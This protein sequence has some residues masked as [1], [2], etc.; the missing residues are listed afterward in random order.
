MRRRIRGNGAR[1]AGF[2]NRIEGAGAACESCLP[3]DLGYRKCKRRNAL[4]LRCQR[5]TARRTASGRIPIPGELMHGTVPSGIPRSERTHRSPA[6][7]AD[8][9]A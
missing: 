9:E 6:G 7:R 4:V 2:P 1:L 3:Q 8:F 5:K